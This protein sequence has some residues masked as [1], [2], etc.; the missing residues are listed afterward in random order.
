MAARDR[1]CHVSERE[2]IMPN[3]SSWQD[4][5]DLDLTAEDLAAMAEA[6]EDVLVSGPAGAVIYTLPLSRG[7]SETTVT[8]PAFG[9][10]G[11]TKLVPA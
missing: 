7:A 1:C 4:K 6:G 9:R 5:D 11:G 10:T 3:M 2:G 8:R